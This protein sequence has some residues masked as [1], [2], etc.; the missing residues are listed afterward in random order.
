[1]LPQ[2]AGMAIMVSITAIGTMLVYYPWS[3]PRFHM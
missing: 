3:L 1:M 2:T